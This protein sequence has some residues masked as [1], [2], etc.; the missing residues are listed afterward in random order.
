MN[1]ETEIKN[2]LELLKKGNNIKVVQ[3]S[4][5]TVINS[6]L[7]IENGMWAF[8]KGATHKVNAAESGDLVIMKTS[9]SKEI[10]GIGILRSKGDNLEEIKD[11]WDDG[12]YYRPIYIDWYKPLTTFPYKEVKK[13]GYNNNVVGSFTNTINTDS[14]EKVRYIELV[15]TK[16]L[17]DTLSE[18]RWEVNKSE[19]EKRNTRIKKS[20]YSRKDLLNQERRGLIKIAKKQSGYSTKG[21]KYWIDTNNQRESL[22]QN[23]IEQ[24]LKKENIPYIRECPIENKDGTKGQVDFY[25]GE[26]YNKG[27]EVK[28]VKGLSTGTRGRTSKEQA[29]SYNCSNGTWLV[30]VDGSIEGSIDYFQLG[31]EIKRF[32][33]RLKLSKLLNK[34]KLRVEKFIDKIFS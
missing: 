29:D 16:W 14:P 22:F 33:W 3:L 11:V 5:A 34:F 32:E 4:S 24:Y 21:A 12:V 27:I 7:G 10:S 2:K 28:R 1:L 23:L 26:P 6:K 9:E 25:L 13:L 18:G 31:K 15:I 19:Y 30:S 20:P 8:N 17:E